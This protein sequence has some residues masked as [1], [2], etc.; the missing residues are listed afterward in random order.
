[1]HRAAHI[2]MNTYWD[3]PGGPVAGTHTSNAR[4]VGSISGWGTRTLHAVQNGQKK[5]KKEREN[6]D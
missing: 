3:Y 5:K 2:K 4:G 1:M 6:A